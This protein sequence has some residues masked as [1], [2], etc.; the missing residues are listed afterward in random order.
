MITLEF[1]THGNDKQKETAIYWND[2]VSK[3][4]VY[5]GA[6]GGGKSYLGCSLIFHDALVYAGTHYFI[7]RKHL[8]DLRKF[9]K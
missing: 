7:A 8:N 3:E 4:I 9:T 5:G 6:K 1:D 2:A